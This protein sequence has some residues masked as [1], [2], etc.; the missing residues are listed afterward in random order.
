MSVPNQ[1][2]W[3]QRLRDQQ[4]LPSATGQ[5]IKLKKKAAAVPVKAKTIVPPAAINMAVTNTQRPTAGVELDAEGKPK[6][7]AQRLREQGVAVGGKTAAKTPKPEKTPVPTEPPATSA[8][9]PP[10]PTGDE[11][12]KS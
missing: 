9:T 1:V 8:P 12:W 5:P 7:L 6:T 10:P 2:N 3:R 11:I 4:A